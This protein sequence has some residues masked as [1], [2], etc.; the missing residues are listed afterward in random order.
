[1]TELRS[2]AMRRL[3]EQG[4]RKAKK[5]TRPSEGHLKSLIYK[6]LSNGWHY[7][8]DYIYDLRVQPKPYVVVYAFPPKTGSRAKFFIETT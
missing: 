6:T 7:Q 4:M 2:P 5:T 1:M 3:L 8:V